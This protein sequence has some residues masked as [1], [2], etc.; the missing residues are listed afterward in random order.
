MRYS[1]TSHVPNHRAKVYQTT[2]QFDSENS[3]HYNISYTSRTEFFL[4]A[5]QI[6][7]EEILASFEPCRENLIPVLHRVQQIYGF[8]STDDLEKTARFLKLSVS[9][10]YGVAT[11]YTQFKLRPPGQ[12][13]FRV[14][15]GTACHVK[16][17]GEVL[18]ELEKRLGIKQGETTADGIYSL[19]T[20]ACFGSCALAPVVVD[21]EQVHGRM[22]PTKV[23][24]LIRGED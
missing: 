2:Q 9:D 14:C 12:R 5:P 16:G 17:A 24:D 10:V 7:I 1:I 19:E 8:L 21:G 22:T 20:E 13:C 11:F 23:N 4:D 18:K 15:R 3:L 6:P